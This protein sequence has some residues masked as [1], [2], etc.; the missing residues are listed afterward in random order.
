MHVY[1][2]GFVPIQMMGLDPS[3][4]QCKYDQL[5]RVSLSSDSC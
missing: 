3:A 2:G 4:P 5:L 1:Y